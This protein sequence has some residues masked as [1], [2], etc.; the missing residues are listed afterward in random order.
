MLTHT[1]AALRGKPGPWARSTA[2]H[3]PPDASRHRDTAARISA[4]ASIL[5][6]AIGSAV[7]VSTELAAPSPDLVAIVATPA[8][9]AVVIALPVLA[10]HALDARR[11][12]AAVLLAVAAAIGSVHTLTS[13]LSRQAEARDARLEASAS[14]ARRR[15]IV[16]QQLA[17]VEGILAASRERHARECA[18]GAGKACAGIQTVIGLS[19]T[20]AAGHRAELARLHLTKPQAGERRIAALLALVTGHSEAR[21]L[22]AVGMMLPALFGLLIEVAASATALHAFAPHR[23]HR[24]VRHVHAPYSAPV[25]TDTAGQS[26]Y[27]A[28]S[29]TAAA[30][31]LAALRGTPGPGPSGGMPTSPAPR[32]PDA[33]AD[34]RKD[35]VLASLLTDLGLGRSA[36]SQRDLCQRFGVARS[37]MSDWLGE[38]ERS[39]LIPPRRTVGRCKAITGA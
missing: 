31:A 20:A 36:A 38:W 32:K 15:A 29:E 6:W 1:T 19:E 5:L 3:T 23:E 21:M 27:P 16:E 33:P 30:E 28:L 11:Y 13:T 17:E 4:G 25:A 24:T 26:D 9:W 2:Q 7:L 34:G 35:E 12:I 18:T 14:T 37:T 10:H 39:G 22:E 8:I